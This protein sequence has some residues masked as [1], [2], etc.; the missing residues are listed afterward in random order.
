MSQV[1]PVT[2]K[3]DS[4][5]HEFEKVND[6]GLQYLPTIFKFHDLQSSDP[7]GS[8]LF[9]TVNSTLLPSQGDMSVHP[10]FI[11]DFLYKQ[12]SPK[13]SVMASL[14]F[15]P[16]S[17]SRLALKNVTSSSTEQTLTQTIQ[18]HRRKN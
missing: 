8:T 4:R 16:P 6:P 7:T 3:M 11:L 15:S 5:F 18:L 12:T 10:A 13:H 17:I 2:V 14:L 9:T 1:G